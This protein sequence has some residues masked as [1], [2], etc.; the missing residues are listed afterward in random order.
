MTFQ[1][2]QEL[3]ANIITTTTAAKKNV[4]YPANMVCFSS[5]LFFQ[6]TDSR[7]NAKSHEAAVNLSLSV[8]VC[9]CS[10]PPAPKV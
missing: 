1:P 6:I 5:K 8:S 4:S 10:P 2:L 7:F 3:T 9:Q